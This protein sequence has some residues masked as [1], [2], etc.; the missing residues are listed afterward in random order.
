MTRILSSAILYLL[1]L[2]VF[3]AVFAAAEESTAANAP[4]ETVSVVYV[5]IFGLF[6]IGLI[7]GFFVYMM[8][9]GSDDKP[10]DKK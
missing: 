6:F 3:A 7:V 8:R 9:G 1:T 4:V 10:E 5:V 2:P